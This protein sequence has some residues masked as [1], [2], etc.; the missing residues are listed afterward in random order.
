MRRKT[1]KKRLATFIASH[2]SSGKATCRQFVGVSAI[3]QFVGVSAIRQFVGLS[4]IC[5]FV[6]LSTICQFVGSICRLD[7]NVSSTHSC[8]C[9]STFQKLVFYKRG[10]G[11]ISEVLGGIRCSASD[12]LEK[13]DAFIEKA[14]EWYT[15]LIGSQT[16]K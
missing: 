6:G 1:K 11:C 14:Y 4:T 13:V 2:M 12:G 15:E 7:C 9:I 16:D 8:C 10:V 3:R 5:Q